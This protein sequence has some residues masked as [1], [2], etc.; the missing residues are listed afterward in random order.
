M[1]YMNMIALL[2]MGLFLIGC[3]S[4]DNSSSGSSSPASPIYVFQ[5]DLSFTIDSVKTEAPELNNHCSSSFANYA[6]SVSCTNFYPFVGR[7]STNGFKS[8]IATNSLNASSPVKLIDGTTTIAS[9]LQ[10]LVDNGPILKGSNTWSGWADAY[11]Y[12]GVA[13]D[14]SAGNNCQ[15]YGDDTAGSTISIGTNAAYFSWTDRSPVCD[16]YDDYRFLCLCN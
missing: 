8:F 1:K 7:T 3:G 13:T 11:W 5:T 16:Y 9:S 12:S 2:S 15:D 4:D 14:G 6:G 10:E